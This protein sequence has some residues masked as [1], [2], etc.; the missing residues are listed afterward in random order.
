MSTWENRP[1]DLK[2]EELNAW[3]LCRIAD[4]V[5]AVSTQIANLGT[6]NAATQMGAIE[7]LATQVHDGCNNVASAIENLM[8]GGGLPLTEGE[9]E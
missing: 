7:F 1:R 9:S 2:S 8:A 4:A 6:G 3:A 5:Y